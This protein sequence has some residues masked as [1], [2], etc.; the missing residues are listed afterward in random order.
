MEKY[1]LTKEGDSKLEAEYRHLLDV[2]RPQNTRDI[3]DARALGDLSGTL[4]TI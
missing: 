4:C 2:V 1:Q 3:V